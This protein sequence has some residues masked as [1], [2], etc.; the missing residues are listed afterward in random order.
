MEM[1]KYTKKRATVSAIALIAGLSAGTSAFAQSNSNDP[2]LDLGEIT[3]FGSGLETTVMDSPASVTVINA[4]DIKRLAPQTVG[5]LLRAVPGLRIESGGFER[6]IIRGE[7]GNRVLIKIDGQALTDHNGM[8]K[9][10]PILVDPA[11]VERIEIIRGSSSVVGGTRAIGGVVN[12]ITKKGGG[13]PFGG[14]FSASYFSATKGYSTNLSLHGKM[15]NFDYRLNLGKTDLDDIETPDGPWS[16]SDFQNRNISTH[17]GYTA[18]NHYFS[19]KL[20]DL[21]MSTNV[22][23]GRPGMFVQL[24]KRD[25]SKVGLYYQGTDLAP[26][27]SKLTANTY[28]QT[29]D[30][31]FISPFGSTS[32]DEAIAYGF[33][34]DAVLEFSQRH[35]TK[36]GLEY[37]NDYIDTFK[38]SRGPATHDKARIKTFSIYALHEAELNDKLTAFLGGRYYKVDADL[39]FSN[40]SPLSSN[41]D[42]RLLGSAALV[43]KPSEQMSL[44]F[45]VNQG[46]TYP[47]LTQMFVTT[48]TRSVING[49]P[50]LKPESSTT[51]EIGARFD[52]GTSV[53]DATMFYTEAEDYIGLAPDMRPGV[54]AGQLTYVNINKA[55]T[56]GLELY[57]EH[58]IGNSNLTPYIS[59]T[60]MRRKLNASYASNIPE[61]FGKVGVR[62]DWELRNG[63]AG[64]LDAYIEGEGEVWNLS[65]GVVSKTTSGYATFN[66][67]AEA[68]I[69]DN[70][71]LNASFNNLFD[72]S[73]DPVNGLPGAERNIKLNLTWKF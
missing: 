13:K 55:K 9:G 26:W 63:I 11:T 17:L 35:R 38:T 47:N 16:P 6:V 2:W 50:N 61:V 19:L 34:V 29:V 51:V 72:K 46:Y 44:R 49:N 71:Q 36:I 54:P 21:D 27:M 28:H 65:R 32:T 5:D 68:A 25:L 57:A 45:G 15:G 52:N 8:G 64:S 1:T 33:N 42:S 23:F 18:G 12:I 31:E 67:A 43:W 59:A 14:S 69:T 41:S 10:T 39:E 53:V 37:E 40:H 3:L 24:P 30:R 70:L 60:W 7:G 4:E 56:F 20:Q 66:I 22:S 58:T 62:Y 73:Y 48:S